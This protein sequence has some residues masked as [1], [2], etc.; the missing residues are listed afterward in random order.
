MK[1]ISKLKEIE[2]SWKSLLLVGLSAM[3]SLIVCMIVLSPEE[4]VSLF[5]K[6][7][8]YGVGLSLLL[9]VAFGV[10]PFL[11]SVRR[12]HFSKVDFSLLGVILLVYGILFSLE[13]NRFKIVLDEPILLGTSKM[14]CEQANP[15]R[16]FSGF[17]F[18]GRFCYG[19]RMLDKRP[20]LYPFLVSMV[21]TVLGYSDKNPMLVNSVVSILLIFLLFLFSRQYSGAWPAFAVCLLFLTIPEFI[22]TGNGGG[23][24]P[25]NLFVILIVAYLGG[26]YLEEGSRDSLN[27][28][29]FSGVLLSMVRPETV[30]LIGAVI[31]VVLIGAVLRRQLI[32]SYWAILIPPLVALYVLQYSVFELDPSHWQ[33]GGISA[34][35]VLGGGYILENLKSNMSYFLNVGAESSNSLSFSLYGALALILTAC[36]FIRRKLFFKGRPF[37]YSSVV[38]C[39]GVYMGFVLLQCSYVGNLLNATQSRYV[40][41]FSLWV[42]VLISYLLEYHFP[43]KIWLYLLVLCPLLVEWGLINFPAMIH[44]TRTDYAALENWKNNFSKQHS[45]KKFLVLGDENPLVWILNEQSGISIAAVN[46]NIDEINFLQKIGYFDEIYYFDMEYRKLNECVLSERNRL[47]EQLELVPVDDGVFEETQAIFKVLD[48]K[49]PPPVD[50]PSHLVHWSSVSGLKD[51]SLKSRIL[52]SLPF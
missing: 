50:M 13:P 38:F 12:I 43:K 19:D 9:A 52:L 35:E 30:M 25:L 33:G 3:V 36:L 21:H 39:L 31:V 7:G 20:I 28:F 11:M 23:I 14:M 47:K 10:R 16:P 17:W 41:P 18:D 2:V 48:V 34:D 27:G 5:L 8:Y 29:I 51:E 22:I 37:L 44:G 26:C 46:A 32:L 6:I 45:D 15:S 4:K 49:L 42:C 24:G 1:L 40:L